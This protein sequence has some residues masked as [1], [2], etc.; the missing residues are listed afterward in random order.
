MD[1]KDSAGREGACCNLDYLVTNL[2][3]NEAAARRLVQIFLDSSPGLVDR[4][5][6]YAEKGDLPRLLHVVHDIR[7]HCTLFSAAECLEKTRFLERALRG[8]VAGEG[9]VY[10][11]LDW[12]AESAELRRL[13][14]HVVAELTAFIARPAGPSDGASAA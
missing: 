9:L 6:V 4:L 11:D 12:V 10:A 2:G 8:L 7:G 14:E 3:R 1:A 5:V 13:L